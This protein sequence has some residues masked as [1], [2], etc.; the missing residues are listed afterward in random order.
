MDWTRGIGLTS[1]LLFCL[2]RIGGKC[3]VVFAPACVCATGFCIARITR[4]LRPRALTHESGPLSKVPPPAPPRCS[5]DSINR[6]R[7]ASGMR[8]VSDIRRDLPV[9]A[10]RCFAFVR[11]AR[12]RWPI[13]GRYYERVQRLTITRTLSRYLKVAIANCSATGV[14][15]YHPS[16]CSDTTVSHAVNSLMAL[17]AVSAF[18]SLSLNFGDV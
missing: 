12:R 3:S 18:R 15:T 5:I 10:R 9:V 1:L 16:R 7:S 2:G 4:W 8:G 6:R 14:N 11:N 17:Y 13:C